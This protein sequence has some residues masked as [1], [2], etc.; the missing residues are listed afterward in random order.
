MKWTFDKIIEE[1][2]KYPSRSKFAKGS[3]VAYRHALKNGMLDIMYP[4]D[5]LIIPRIDATTVPV[6]QRQTVAKLAPKKRIKHMDRFDIDY[7]H[8]DI[9]RMLD[10]MEGY[11]LETEIR[12]AREHYTSEGPHHIEHFE[13]E[14]ARL[15]K[16]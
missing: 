16:L 10:T 8:D 7:I 1:A 9:A 6:I 15:M 4:I 12:R 5:V 13:Y 11:E 2:K 14:L 3:S